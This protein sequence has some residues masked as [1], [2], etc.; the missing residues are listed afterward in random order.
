MPLLAEIRPSF[1]FSVKGQQEG[2]DAY[3]KLRLTCSLAG[4]GGVGSFQLNSPI[5]LIEFNLSGGSTR[6]VN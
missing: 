4:S 1:I 5:Q 2:G 6:W 3:V